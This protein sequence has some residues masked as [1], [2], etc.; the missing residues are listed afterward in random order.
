MTW[1]HR[2]ILAIA[3]L[4]LTG[5]TRVPHYTISTRGGEAEGK[6]LDAATDPDRVNA[7]ATEIELLSPGNVDPNEA[8]E[9]ARVG[10]YYSE[11]LA[12]Y[13]GMIK[14]V[15]MHNVLVNLGLRKGG[16]CY[17]YAENLLAELRTRNLQTL[18]LHRGIAWHGKLFDEHNCVVVTAKGQPFESGIVLDAWRNAGHL[19]WAPV[20][21]DYYPWVP[22]PDPPQEH[23]PP[24]MAQTDSN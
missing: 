6:K 12:D 11:Q 22:K 24:M 3:F 5:C 14:W 4:A 18:E 19:R 8:N 20:S 13:F 23:Q 1:Q 21:K 2:F 16:L 15:E 17:Q 9:V 7:L 10:V